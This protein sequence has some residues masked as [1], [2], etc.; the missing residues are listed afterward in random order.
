MNHVACHVCIS[1]EMHQ[2]ETYILDSLLCVS[3][4]FHI[5]MGVPNFYK[6]V[7]KHAAH[8]VKN[9]EASDLKGSRIGID[10]P[11]LVHRA[12]AASGENAPRY[13]A[14]KLIWLLGAEAQ[15]LMVFDGKQSDDFKEA[16]RC[17]RG[18]QRKAQETKADE[19]ERRMRE[20]AEDCQEIEELSKSIKRLR[21]GC[22]KPDQKL[23]LILIDICGK[24]Y[25]PCIFAK[26]EAERH[27]AMLSMAGMIDYVAT[28]DSD[29]LINGASHVLT[30]CE[31]LPLKPH[32][33]CVEIYGV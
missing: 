14:E 8:A 20:D 32:S 7:S 17:R 4:H 22:T 11:M 5:V 13:L 3:N 25:I 29:A 26:G 15:V 31:W 6:L 1:E 12:V 9:V 21:D 27:L 18:E 33:H 24:L 23:Y 10:A 2:Q 19:L 30:Q 16:E 28:E